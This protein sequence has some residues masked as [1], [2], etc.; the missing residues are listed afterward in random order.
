MIH[1]SY[2]RGT[3]CIYIY[4][5][6]F[7]V[8]IYTKACINTLL[9]SQS[10]PGAHHTRNE[11]V[12]WRQSLLFL[13][14]LSEEV[15]NTRTSSCFLHCC[16]HHIIYSPL[17]FRYIYYFDGLLSG[18]IKMNSNPLFLHQVLI[19]SLPNFQAGGG[20]F[21]VLLWF[22]GL[23]KNVKEKFVFLHFLLDLQVSTLFWKSTSL[24][25]WST[26]LASSKYIVRCPVA[27]LCVQVQL[28]DAVYKDQCLCLG[29]GLSMFML[30]RA[31]LPKWDMFWLDLCVFQACE[32]VCFFHWMGLCVCPVIHRTPGQESCVWLWSQHFY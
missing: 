19:P 32:A 25:S 31:L 10:G 7:L 5:K 11:K 1:S 30:F 24:Y 29:V 28:T 3:T 12:L 4:S 16:S 18:T 9:C 21:P 14:A 6:C 13:T 8:Q 15:W 20:Q 26:P 22:L 23:V 2:K 27:P 17:L